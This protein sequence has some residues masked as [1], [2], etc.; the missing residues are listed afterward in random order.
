[1]LVFSNTVKS[2]PGHPRLHHI[3]TVIV[4]GRSAA[5]ITRTKTT[6]TAAQTTGVLYLKKSPGTLAMLAGHPTHGRLAL[7]TINKADPIIRTAATIIAA[8]LN[9]MCTTYKTNQ[10]HMGRGATASLV[11]MISRPALIVAIARRL[12]HGAMPVLIRSA[13][14][15]YRLIFSTPVQRGGFYLTL[16]RP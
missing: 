1:M 6:S 10:P 2:S 12:R 16:A 14:W 11:S 8:D 15:Q 4:V 5:E 3:E 13:R 9:L 7:V